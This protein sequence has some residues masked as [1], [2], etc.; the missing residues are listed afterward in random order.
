M[1]NTGD[2]EITQKIPIVG[3]KLLDLVELYRLVQ[4][5]GGFEKVC[6]KRQ[7]SAVVREL[8]LPKTITSAANTLRNQFA[9]FLYRFECYQRGV[10]VNEQ[11]LREQL[12]SPKPIKEQ[13][14]Q[15]RPIKQEDFYYMNEKQKTRGVDEMHPAFPQYYAQH[16]ENP[17]LRLS[18]Q[19]LPRDTVAQRSTSISPPVLKRPRS[20]EIQRR[21]SYENELAQLEEE[22]SKSVDEIYSIDRLVKRRRL[23]YEK[24]GGESIRAERMPSKEEEESVWAA[25]NERIDD[26]EQSRP[27]STF[28]RSPTPDDRND[29]I[30]HDKERSISPSY[31]DREEREK[32]DNEVEQQQ[33]FQSDKEREH[34]E[35]RKSPYDETWR[36]NNTPPIHP[37]PPSSFEHHR[38]SFTSMATEH[39]NQRQMAARYHHQRPDYATQRKYLQSVVTSGRHSSSAHLHAPYPEKCHCDDCVQKSYYMMRA[40]RGKPG[41]IQPPKTIHDKER[42]PRLPYNH[43]RPFINTRDFEPKET[44]FSSEHTKPY[45][46]LPNDYRGSSNAVKLSTNPTEMNLNIKERTENALVISVVVDGIYYSGTLLTNIKR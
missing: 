32:S 7:L 12:D 25:V 23:S 35:E 14:P 37:P 43:V 18:S 31:E 5:H 44:R 2:T 24:E 33:R 15:I 38:T 16:P 46:R 42:P 4:K 17:L 22:R 11:F 34:Y 9:R 6:Q 26:H 13:P 10:R 19:P 45:H 36:I 27:P 8:N 21:K 20:T 41:Y 28:K 29:T 1:V 30:T 3:R 40:N 39:N